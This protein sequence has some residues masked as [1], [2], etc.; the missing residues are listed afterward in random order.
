MIDSRMQVR[1]K[2]SRHNGIWSPKVEVGEC[3]QTN[4]LCCSSVVAEDCA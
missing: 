4:K 1:A 3:V 2:N